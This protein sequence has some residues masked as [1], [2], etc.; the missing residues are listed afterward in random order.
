MK[1]TL[2]ILILSAADVRAT[3]PMPT[4]IELLAKALRLRDE[5]RATNPLR[6]KMLLPEGR[7]LLGMMPAELSPIAAAGIK[8]VAVLPE[9][10]GSRY[11]SHQGGVLLFETE[12]GQ[13]LALADASEITAIR[14]GAA[15]AV[16]TQE[17]ARA[18]AGDLAI[19]GSGVQARSHLAAMLAVRKL[20]RVRVWSRNEAHRQRFVE[21]ESKKHNVLL[22][23]ATSVA[24]AV[25]GADLICT[26][27][28]ATK[29]ILYSDWVS[30][31]AH[32]NAVGS[33]VPHARELDSLLVQKTRVFV[34]SAE[35]ALNEAG[36]L[37][38]AQ[39]EGHFAPAD[40]QA[41]LGAILNGK[42]PGRETPH[43]ITLFKSLGIGVYDLIAVHHCY[44]RARELGLG[45]W[46]PFGELR[47]DG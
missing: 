42:D 4:C 44:E 6:E 3:L 15:S 16:A 21:Q 27:T 19:L 38:I 40:I 45:V 13:P 32:I 33:S 14:T 30:P 34:E 7:G 29:P 22:E 5:G 20:R 37:L 31:G 10:H 12:R 2:E 17:L 8:V 18:D 11:D 28:S 43:E 47:D 35:S 9:N 24:A 46:A 41:E 26:T 1:Q 39:H 23:T 25:A 36:D